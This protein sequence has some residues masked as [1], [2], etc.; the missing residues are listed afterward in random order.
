MNIKK[1]SKLYQYL[2]WLDKV[3]ET[4][5]TKSKSLC[6]LFWKTILMT[7]LLPIFLPFIGLINL[8]KIVIDKYISKMVVPRYI[9]IG[10]K[11]I[12]FCI[13]VAFVCFIACGLFYLTIT[14][15]IGMGILLGGLFLIMSVVWGVMFLLIIYLPN[16]AET[17]IIKTKEKDTSIKDFV[18]E[19]FSSIKNRICP[20]I[21]FVEEKGVF[22]TA[23]VYKE[24]VQTILQR[25]GYY[26]SICGL[27]EDDYFKGYYKEEAE[28]FGFAIMLSISANQNYSR[29]LFG[30]T[31]SEVRIKFLNNVIKVLDSTSFKSIWVTVEEAYQLTKQEL[32]GENT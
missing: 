8:A 19:G 27:L 14:D 7:L 10:L 6:P 12:L 17:T 26:E 2:S 5:L 11:I 4:K 20:L 28:N 24:L 1:S 30:A 3:Y 18:V 23:P 31:T 9:K 13:L 21:N 15:P 22:E 16:K 25:I 29:Y 32:Y